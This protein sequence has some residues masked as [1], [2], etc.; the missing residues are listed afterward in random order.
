M[1]LDHLDLCNDGDD[2]VPS[3]KTWDDNHANLQVFGRIYSGNTPQKWMITIESKIWGFFYFTH[4]IEDKKT[5]CTCHHTIDLCPLDSPSVPVWPPF[6]SFQF[7]TNSF[8]DL[9]H[10]YR[11]LSK[12]GWIVAERQ[13]AREGPLFYPEEDID[14][15]CSI[16]KIIALLS[17]RE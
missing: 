9:L 15:L 11:S 2:S 8:N 14:P 4:E 1:S 13:L 3:K 16:V 10:L 6:L 5:S 17:I 7:G 12:R